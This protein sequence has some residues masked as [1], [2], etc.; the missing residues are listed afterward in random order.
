MSPTDYGW[1]VL[2]FPLA[3]LIVI[4]LAWRVLPGRTAGWI[5]SGAILGAFL[6]SIGMLVQLQDLPEAQREVVDSG[7]SYVVTSG[8]DVDVSILTDSL[9]V[10]MCLVVS[11]V[12]FLIHVYSVAY[13]TG[14]RGFARFF[15]Y[16][17]Y[18]VFSMLL[19]VLAGN[20]ILL[21]VGWASATCR[22]TDGWFRRSRPKKTSC[23]RPGPATRRTRRRSSPVSTR[24]SRSSTRCAARKALQLSG[25]QQKLVALGRALMAGRKLL[26][27]DEPFEGV[28]PVLARRLAEVIAGLR[29]SGLSVILSESSMTHA[30]GLLDRVFTIDRGAVSVRS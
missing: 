10:F 11:G 28:A 17:N 27:L 18:F 23:C 8:V 15:A 19:L 16:L 4:S 12:S 29:Q 1:L 9:S 13:M 22:R 21:I 24:P 5:G 30:H 6:A 14:D 2:A 26:L 25:G 20:F 3:G 7:W